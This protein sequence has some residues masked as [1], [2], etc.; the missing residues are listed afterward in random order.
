MNRIW[1]DMNRTEMLFVLFAALC[2]AGIVSAT[3]P[4]SF[5]DQR[6]F[7]YLYWLVRIV[8]ECGLFVAF[9]SLFETTGFFGDRRIALFGA[10][11]A[12]SLFPFVLAMTALD[13][14][15]GFPELGLSTTPLEGD[16]FLREFLFE[17]VYLADDHLFVCILLSLPRFLDFQ[18][19]RGLTEGEKAE[20]PALVTGPVLPTLD[21]PLKGT[22]VRVEAQEHYVIINSSEEQRM[23]LGRF[24]DIV[25]TL[26]G[27]L[28]LQVHRS[29]WVARAAVA[30]AFSEKRNLK[31]RL[32]N[33]DV[34]PVSRRYRDAVLEQFETA[35]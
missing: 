11:F 22:L 18:V 5:A 15:L 2:A 33:G 17:I 31:L 14:V 26:P 25:N 29:H 24:S 23:V 34:V 19:E 27:P 3:N 9:R 32:A 8:I 21:P 35:A 16:T 4:N 7:L 1:V 28:G 6:V 20:Q 13:I 12:V 10:A 30:E